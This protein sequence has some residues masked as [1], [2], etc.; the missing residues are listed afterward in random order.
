MREKK[1]RFGNLA[2]EGGCV[3]SGAAGKPHLPGLAVS[4]DEKARLG[5]LASEGGCVISGA[6]GKPHLPCLGCS[7][8]I[9][10]SR[11][12][13]WRADVQRKRLNSLA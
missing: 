9:R 3:I 4:N 5:N 6:V 11:L 13:G 10:K 1:A 8:E 2:S 12:L 7:G